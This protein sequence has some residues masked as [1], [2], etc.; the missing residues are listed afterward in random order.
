MSLRRLMPPTPIRA[1][2]LISIAVAA[3]A[4]VALLRPEAGGV[5]AAPGDG[6]LKPEPQSKYIIEGHKSNIGVKFTTC[7]DPPGDPVLAPCYVGAYDVTLNYDTTKL[8]KVEDG[9]IATS[10]TSTTLTDTTR[11]WK[12]NQWVGS[13]LIIT[14]GP[15]FGNRRTVVSNT[16]TTLTVTPAFNAP[17]ASQP[18]AGTIYKVGGMAEGGWLGSTGRSVTCAVGP[19][20]GV[21]FAKLH[22]VTLGASPP[23]P[24]GAGNLVNLTIGT[25]LDCPCG[26]TAGLVNLTLT[27]VQILQIDGTTI[28][29]DIFNGTRR[30]ILCPDVNGVDGKVN[31]IDLSLTAQQFGKTTGQP[32]YSIQRD[33]NESGSINSTDLSIIAGVF[34]QFCIQP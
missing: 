26:P 18:G 16:A 23:G 28:P 25:L 20:Y 14:G 4:A 32:G 19:E 7:V 2:L 29:V 10:G 31:S 13:Q 27:G 11:A 33:P 12:V 15:G 5:D 24:T 17:P 30:V 8:Q 22:C 6:Q 3:F 1:L 21:G 9:N 34:N